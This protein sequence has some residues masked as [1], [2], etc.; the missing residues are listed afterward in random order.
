MTCSTNS[1]SLSL[2]WS[3]EYKRR[4][5]QGSRLAKAQWLFWDFETCWILRKIQKLCLSSVGMFCL[6]LRLPYQTNSGAIDGLCQQK[7]CRVQ[8]QRRNCEVYKA[9]QRDRFWS[10]GSLRDLTQSHCFPPLQRDRLVLVVVALQDPNGHGSRGMFLAMPMPC[11]IPQRLTSI[12]QQK[13]KTP[14][15]ETLVP[16]FPLAVS[17]NILEIT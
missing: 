1:Q 9:A 5:D 15:D 17:A 7:I 2:W 16:A 14:H 8:K 6:R 12:I 13:R 3:I 4:G 11:E 10:E